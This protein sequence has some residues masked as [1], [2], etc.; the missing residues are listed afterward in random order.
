[1]A[2]DGPEQVWRRLPRPDGDQGWMRS[3][4]DPRWAAVW[5][6]SV[7]A[8]RCG[9][10]NPDRALPGNGSAVSA[11]P[12][13]G[14]GRAGNGR[15]GGSGMSERVARVREPVLLAGSSCSN[16]PSGLYAVALCVLS[17]SS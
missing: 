16:D 14:Q 11:P 8:I 10:T 6:K 2:L 3:R 4:C 15:P 13:A 7:E 17:C 12:P 9:W 1:M 5:G